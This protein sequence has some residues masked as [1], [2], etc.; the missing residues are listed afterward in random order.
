[1]A[2]SLSFI[3]FLLVL[4]I[5]SCDNLPGDSVRPLE[6]VIIRDTIYEVVYIEVSPKRSE[7]QIYVDTLKQFLGLREL[8]G[9]NDHPLIDKFFDETCGLRNNPWCAAVLSYA[10][11]V[12]GHNIPLQPC[13]TPSFFPEERVTWRRGDNRKLR[14]GEIFG[15]Y[16]KS[17]GRIAHVGVVVEDFGDGWV[18][19]YEGNTN[20]QGGREG[21]GFYSRL[22]HKS[23]LYVVA[24][25]IS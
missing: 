2:K 16:F 8:T 11:K 4:I 22:R 7:A 15:L 10:L 14:E 5:S 1:M 21:N 18:L 20:D 3:I 19:S 25:W 24:D 13:Y 9:K 23:Q 17:L 12:N 6:P